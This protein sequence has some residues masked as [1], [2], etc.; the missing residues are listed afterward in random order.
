MDTTLTLSALVPIYS[1]SLLHG[2]FNGPFRT[3][4]HA[5]TAPSAVQVPDHQIG[6]RD[7]GLGIRAPWAPQGTALEKDRG[8]DPRAVMDAES[9]DIK[10]ETFVGFIH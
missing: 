10:D 3:D 7:L 5:G 2:H 8:S 6:G 1:A 4:L 9:L